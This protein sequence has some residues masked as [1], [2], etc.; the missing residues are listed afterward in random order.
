M[1][2]LQ[3]KQ[4]LLIDSMNGSVEKAVNKA[5]GGLTSELRNRRLLWEGQ[6]ETQLKS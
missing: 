4:Q 3:S 2:P 5:V 1:S 6:M